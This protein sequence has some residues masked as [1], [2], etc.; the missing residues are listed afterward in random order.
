MKHNVFKFE[1][2]NQ[3]EVLNEDALG[4]IE[5]DEYASETQIFEVLKSK[6]AD[7]LFIRYADGIKVDWI[8]Y[9]T[10]YL[11]DAGELIGCIEVQQAG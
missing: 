3:N 8:T 2:N 6:F 5:I 11:Y 4:E 9:E 1:V 7:E 10:A